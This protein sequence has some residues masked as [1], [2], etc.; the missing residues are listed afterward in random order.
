MSASI[1]I[2]TKAEWNELDEVRE[3]AEAFF[4][5]QKVK[6]DDVHAMVMVTCE[7]AENAVK[8]GQFDGERSQ[9]EVTLTAD[10]AGLTTEVRSP[11]AAG[12]ERHLERSD[13][14]IQ[15]I[16]GF[17]DPHQA[18]LERLREV[19]SQA[20]EHH[21]S[22]LGLVRVAYEGQATLDFYID[23][24]ETVCVSAVRDREAN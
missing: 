6:V 10:Q 18:Y 22:G 12:G 23:D 8:Y 17:Q 15:W 21:E 19:S 14:M 2:S 16:R 3:R 5:E 7:L 13:E 4:T 20:L 24:T 9:L 11:L 1:T